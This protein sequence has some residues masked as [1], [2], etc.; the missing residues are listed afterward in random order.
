[1][2]PEIEECL[3]AL[4]ESVAAWGITTEELLERLPLVYQ[5]G[6]SLPVLSEAVEA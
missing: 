2:D 1:M 3:R 5:A 6:E 4:A